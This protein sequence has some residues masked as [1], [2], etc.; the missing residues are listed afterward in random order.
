MSKMK[1]LAYEIEQLYIEGMNA[2]QISRQ[3]KCSKHLVLDWIAS[4]IRPFDEWP[5][6]A[7]DRLIADIQNPARV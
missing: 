7:Q 5:K 1:D 4:N 6:Q 2:G 3:L